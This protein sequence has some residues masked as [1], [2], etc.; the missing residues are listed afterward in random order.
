MLYCNDFGFE[1]DLGV[2]QLYCLMTGALL[3]AHGRTATCAYREMLAAREYCRQDNSSS[4]PLE[5]RVMCKL[6]IPWC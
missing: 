6:S 1:E 3:C 4:N 5:R 2:Q